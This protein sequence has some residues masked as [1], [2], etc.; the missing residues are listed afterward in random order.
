[1]TEEEEE[2]MDRITGPVLRDRPAAGRDGANPDRTGDA[3]RDDRGLRPRR[4]AMPPP[5]A[6]ELARMMAEFHARGGAI[7]VCP[8][9]Y[10]LPIQGGAAA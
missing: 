3:G 8:P 6:A 5:G 7:T 2:G 4:R 9:V 10:V 1:M